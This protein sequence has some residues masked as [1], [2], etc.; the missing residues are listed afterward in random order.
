MN[1]TNIII[2]LQKTLRE[3]TGLSDSVIRQLF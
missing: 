3:H 2:Q 1:D